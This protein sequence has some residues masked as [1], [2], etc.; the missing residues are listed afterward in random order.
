MKTKTCKACRS[1]NEDFAIVC[2][3]CGARIG[4]PPPPGGGVSAAV[5]GAG[6][7]SSSVGSSGGVGS[8]GADQGVRPIT[9]APPPMPTGP[10]SDSAWGPPPPPVQTPQGVQPGVA[11]N[12]HPGVMPKKSNA[13]LM[14]GFV[15]FIALLG[16]AVV[17]FLTSG[18]GGGFPEVLA[19]HPRSD[20]EIAKQV[21]EAFGSFD[22]QGMSID[23]AL[24]GEGTPVAM[25]MTLD[26]LPAAATDMPADVFFDG[27][28][29][30]IAQQQGLG[31]D[32][33]AGV[34]ASA[35]GADFLCVDAPAGSLSGGFSTG[36]FGSAQGG[37]FCAFRGETVGIVMLFDGTTASVAM[38][39]VQQAYDEIS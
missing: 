34:R 25:F 39:A 13:G 37:A 28:A 20:S 16:A 10:V 27:F 35:N 38:P 1:V 7:A 22:V 5:G 24:Y 31:I 36:G 3:N 17:Y 9:S 18:G 11:P 33:G 19:G 12:V 2:R 32:I 30:G 14:I 4:E 23:V 8:G 6:D 15:L 21:E 29:A 26:G